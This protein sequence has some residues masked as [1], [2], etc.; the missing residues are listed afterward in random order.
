MVHDG[1]ESSFVANVKA[2]QGLDPTL[3]ELKEVELKKSVKA[4]SQEGDGVLPNIDDLR[5]RILSEA[6]SSR[7]FIHPR[8]T[9]MYFDL[10][11]V[12][13][14]NEMKKNIA[15]FVAKCLN[16]QQ[17]KVEQQK[18]EVYPK[19]LVSLFVSGKI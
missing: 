18:R 13:W 12:Y 7:Y 3:V 9:K 16:C 19:I 4:F 14:W 11:E 5:G 17:V 15:E 10:R 1:S 2:K 6:R 8:A